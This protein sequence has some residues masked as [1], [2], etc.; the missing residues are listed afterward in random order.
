MY[1]SRWRWLCLK[2]T[3]HYITLHNS[4]T[5]VLKNLRVS[6]ACP[7]RVFDSIRRVSSRPGFPSTL[8]FVARALGTWTVPDEGILHHTFHFTFIDRTLSSASHLHQQRPP[9]PTLFAAQTNDQ[10]QG[11]IQPVTWVSKYST[12][13]RSLTLTNSRPSSHLILFT[14]TSTTYLRHYGATIYWSHL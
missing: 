14:S 6:L 10:Q 4:L 8:F 12:H 11:N 9:N 3:L 2:S 13:H 5:L 7:H 1:V